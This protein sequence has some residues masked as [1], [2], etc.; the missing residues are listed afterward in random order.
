MAPA[1]NERALPATPVV[2][3]VVPVPLTDDTRREAVASVT[4]TCVVEMLLAT[5]LDVYVYVPPANEGER[6]TPKRERA[7][8]LED[9]ATVY[10]P[11][12]PMALSSAP[13]FTAMA[14]IGLATEERVMVPPEVTKEL[15]VVGVDPLVV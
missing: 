10:V 5:A 3:V 7:V 9:A 1:V 2:R 4:V 6:V 13:A 11:D 12:V 8:R 14:L 15:P